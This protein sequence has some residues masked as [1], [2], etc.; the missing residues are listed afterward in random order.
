MTFTEE[1][2]EG[3]V[4][5]LK[6]AVTGEADAHG[7]THTTELLRELDIGKEHAVGQIICA[8][9]NYATNGEQRDMVKA[10]AYAF[11]AW[12]YSADEMRAEE[13][14]FQEAVKNIPVKHHRKQSR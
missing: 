3:F 10:A 13:K 11:I 6:E 14:A 12:V 7:Y 5:W 9:T 2:W 4:E 1:Q 8:A